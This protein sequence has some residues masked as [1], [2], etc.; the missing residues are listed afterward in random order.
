MGNQKPRV[1][2]PW[3]DAESSF[4]ADPL[5]IFLVENLESEPETC[6]EFLFPLQEHRGR[7]RD[8]DLADFFA[9]QQLTCDQSGFDRLTETHVVGDEQIDAW[10]TQGL[11]KW[12]KLVGVEPNPCTERR[13]KQIRVGRCNAVP[14]ERVEVGGKQ[15]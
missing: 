8:D 1:R 5:H 13:L 15:R 12:F 11:A 7:A 14:L 9:Q 3:I 10:Q 2:A 6:F 4:A